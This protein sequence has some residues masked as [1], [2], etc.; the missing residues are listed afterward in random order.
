VSQAAI[1]N[2]QGIG[3]A[4]D[5]LARLIRFRLDW[6][7]APQEASGMSHE[8]YMVSAQYR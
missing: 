4:Y 7:S 5:L 8:T 3:F 2:P 6:D 1:E